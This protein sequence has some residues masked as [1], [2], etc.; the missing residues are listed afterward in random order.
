M[1]SGR[2]L[3]E[4]PLVI[5]QE[6]LAEFGSRLE[7]P[8]RVY[9]R[10]ARLTWDLGSRDSRSGAAQV[11]EADVVEV[12][13]VVVVVV[14]VVAVGDRDLWLVPRSLADSDG[15]SGD[16]CA[17][18]SEA[19]CQAGPRRELRCQDYLS[20]DV[21]RHPEVFHELQQQQQLPLHSCRVAGSVL[22]SYV[23]NRRKVIL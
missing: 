3:K 10:L 13:V 5:W 14:D 6:G 21:L 15:G 20:Q 4:E 22:S 8:W 19:L 23:C 17:A 16:D 11:R 7:P 12:V 2:L 9:R 1:G 18:V